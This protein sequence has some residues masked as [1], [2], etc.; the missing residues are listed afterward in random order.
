MLLV[1]PKPQPEE[2][3]VGYL[4]RISVENGYSS[5]SQVKCLIKA[6]Q[7]EVERNLINNMSIYRLS[8]YTGYNHIDFIRMTSQDL[9]S[10]IHIHQYNQLLLRHIVQ[11]CPLCVRE[12]HIHQKGWC[13]SATSICLT[14]NSWLQGSCSCSRGLT[15]LSFANGRCAYCNNVIQDLPVIH[16]PDEYIIFLQEQLN[17]LFLSTASI[18]I[19]NQQVSITQF[20]ALTKHSHSLLHDTPSFLYEGMRIMD[21]TRKGKHKQKSCL[22]YFEVIE[23]YRD[24]PNRFVRVL[25]DQKKKD[26]SAQTIAKYN[27]E[28]ILLDPTW[29]QIKQVYMEYKQ[30]K[31]PSLFVR[32]TPS[33]LNASHFSHLSK[34]AASHYLG[35]GTDVVNKLIQIG[36]LREEV[37]GYERK[38]PIHELTYLLERSK[39]E[40]GRCTGRITLRDI[41]QMY[42]GRVL[43]VTGIIQLVLSGVLKTMSDEFCNSLKDIT[44]E[45]SELNY[46]FAAA[47]L[48]LMMRGVNKMKDSDL[49]EFTMGLALV[50]G[51]GIVFNGYTYTNS[52][53]IKSQWFEAAQMNG[54]WEIPVLYNQ[55]EPDLLLL[56]D[57]NGLEVASAVEEQAE[58]NEDTLDAYHEAINELKLRIMKRK[59]K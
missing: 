6:G 26:P 54:E 3:M 16:E 51:R 48:T 28:K 56:Y 45:Q 13:L 32:K 47:E 9:Y 35:I 38:I 30:T 24:F 17:Q 39:G 46:C 27:F 59:D 40:Q 23:M 49:K 19:L 15:H 53:M 12:R 41:I 57:L 36:I 34:T 37:I 21:L 11:Y 22:S 10:H 8:A 52:R 43:N 42:A 5:I 1:R 44:F 7:R 25:D 18:P 33:A 20:L 29:D 2:S 4:H 58:I 14:H 50:T 31:K 55:A